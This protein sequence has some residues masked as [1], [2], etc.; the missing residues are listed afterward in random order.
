MLVVESNKSVKI[1]QP[2][3]HPPSDVTKAYP[4]TNKLKIKI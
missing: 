2:S 1:G 4:D 3:R